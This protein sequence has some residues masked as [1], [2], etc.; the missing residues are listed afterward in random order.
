V[1]INGIEMVVDRSISDVEIAKS[2]IKKGL[3]GMTEEEKN[4][5]LTGLKGAYNYTDFNRLESAVEYLTQRIIDIP[6][7]IEYLKEILGVSSDDI[8]DVAYN[9][10]DYNEIETKTDWK[11][12]DILTK[13]D[14]QR[15]LQNIILILNSLDLLPN[16]FPQSLEN[17]THSS[18]NVIE[19]SLE[20]LNSSLIDLKK[21]KENLIIN[22]SKAWYYSGDLYGGEI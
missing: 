22:T 11:I 13:N 18:A 15:Y 17:L 7:E 2:L 19:T 5:F 4:Q 10:D 1:A 9:K 12:S 16:N 20:N 8:F 21:T 14:R 6:E 3:N